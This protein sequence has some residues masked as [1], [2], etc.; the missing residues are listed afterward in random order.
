MLL[1]QPAVHDHVVWTVA[2]GSAQPQWAVRV[3]RMTHKGKWQE[4]VQTVVVDVMVGQPVGVGFGGVVT[5]SFATA[6]PMLFQRTPSAV[7]SLRSRQFVKEGVRLAGLSVHRLVLHGNT[8]GQDANG[9]FH[10]RSGKDRRLDVGK[11]EAAA[12]EWG[13]DQASGAGWRS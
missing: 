5:T 13:G 3:S 11:L 1:L 10:T 9:R 8:S 6:Y 7:C 2:G 12:S 4:E